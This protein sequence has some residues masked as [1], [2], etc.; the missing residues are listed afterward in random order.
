MFRLCQSSDVPKIYLIERLTQAAPWSEDIF[1]NCLHAAYLGWVVEV[2]KQL[3]AFIFIAVQGDESHILNIAVHP[4]YQRQ[5]WGRKLLT[6]AIE[7]IKNKGATM[8]YLEV[9]RSN[10]HAIGLYE[11]LGFSAISERKDYYPILDGHEDA[12]VLARIL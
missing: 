12:F 4:S 7:E 3:I 10:S 9:R 6:Y 5:G 11:Q 1:Y 2:D 8:A